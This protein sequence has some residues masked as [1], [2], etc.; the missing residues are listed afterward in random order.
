MTKRSTAESISK[1]PLD[2]AERLRDLYKRVQISQAEFAADYGIGSQ[3]QLWQFLHP[4][5][6]RGRPL[7]VIAAISFAK[8][9]NALGIRCTV[10]TFSPSLQEVID[11]I[12]DFS[13]TSN[14]L[15]IA[16]QRAEYETPTTETVRIMQMLETDRQQ[17][18]LDYAIERLNL[19]QQQVNQN[20]TSRT[21]L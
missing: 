14:V 5:A 4:E 19:Q 12:S 11:R 21:G 2:D 6:D 15:R 13:S 7:N 20:S 18:V 1:A 17:Q 9:L 3:A 10:G 16:Q 8:G